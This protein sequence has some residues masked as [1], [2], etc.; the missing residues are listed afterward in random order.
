MV[1]FVGVFGVE[2][3]APAIAF[4]RLLQMPLMPAKSADYSLQNI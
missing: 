4:S 2:Q 3:N 1:G